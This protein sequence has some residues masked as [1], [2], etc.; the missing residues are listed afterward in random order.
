MDERV[1]PHARHLRVDLGY[2]HAGIFHRGLGGPHLHPVATETV[3]VGRGDRDERHINGQ[4]ALSKKPG[5]LVQEDGREVGSALPHRTAHVGA[6]EQR[7]DL[8]GLC[9]LWLRIFGVARGEHMDDLHVTQF[10]GT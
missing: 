1:A 4:I 2:H 3:L 5:Y 7:I 8:E 9:V 6:D 10:R